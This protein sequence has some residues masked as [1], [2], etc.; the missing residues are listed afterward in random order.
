MWACPWHCMQRLSD[1]ASGPTMAEGVLP[2]CANVAPANIHA[3][4]NAVAMRAGHTR[5]ALVG[6]GTGWSD[7]W[8]MALTDSDVHALKARPIERSSR[9]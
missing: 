4:I 3:T 9:R 5:D 6:F 2:L 1:A 7:L 8:F